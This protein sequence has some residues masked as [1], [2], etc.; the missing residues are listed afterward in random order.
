[1]KKILLGLILFIC[2]SC[3]NK[4]EDKLYECIYKSYN[5]NE[6][7]LSD[8][9]KEIEDDLIEQKILKDNSSNSYSDLLKNIS[10]GYDIYFIPSEKFTILFNNVNKE[11]VTSLNS[12]YIKLKGKKEYKNSKL[13]TL[14]DSLIKNSEISIQKI[15]DLYLKIIPKED[16]TNNYYKY[17]IFF[18]LLYVNKYNNGILNQTSGFKGVNNKEK[19]THKSLDI[20][21]NKND[22]IIINSNK[23]SIN[24]FKKIVYDFEKENESITEFKIYSK[25]ETSYAFY[26]KVE[27]YINVEVEILKNEMAT[28]KYKNNYYKLSEEIQKEINLIYPINITNLGY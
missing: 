16:L 2:V 24:S 12:C 11:N 22:E 9:F 8:V 21:L 26:V 14:G 28:N 5:L 25:G 10:N 4:I 1:M 18:I 27:N 15:S 3:Q 23:T 7:E 6:V 19:T 17:K 20:K 13:K